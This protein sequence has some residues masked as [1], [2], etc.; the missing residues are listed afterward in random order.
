MPDKST[1]NEDITR[2]SFL[3]G[4]ATAVAGAA[5]IAAGA[6]AQPAPKALG[7]PHVAGVK[8]TFPSGSDTLDGFLVRPKTPA[9]HPGVV[10]VPGIFGVSE[11][12][13]ESAAELAQNGFAALVVNYFARTPE[14]A[15]EQDF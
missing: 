5:T 9:R 7:D 11:Y 14:M 13:R 8:V 15:N 10:I 2:R 6:G 4:A 3:G 1:Y 12:M